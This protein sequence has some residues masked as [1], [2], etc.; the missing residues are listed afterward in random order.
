[1][2]SESDTIEV[3]PRPCWIAGHAEQGERTVT[4]LHPY[5]GTEIADVAV[6][7]TEQVERAVAAA[8]GTARAFAASPAHVRADVCDAIAGLIGQRSE[9]IAE[10]IT[11]ENGKPLNGAEAEVHAAAATFR[12]A[13]AEARQLAGDLRRLD[14]AAGGERR[15]AIVRH[16]PLGPVLAVS[17][18]TFPLGAVA[19]Q[20]APALAVGAPVIV[21]PA[22][23]TP[24]T[25][26][27]LG[28]IL[29]E[30]G[31]PEGAFSVLPVAEDVLARLVTDPQLPVIS[32]AGQADEGWAIADAAP[33]KHVLREPLGIGSVVVCPD[34]SSDADLA[35]AAGKIATFDTAR[36]VIV[37]ASVAE[38][39]VP[40]L[41]DTVRA[42]RTGSPHD[43]EVQVGPLIDEATAEQTVKWITSA[44][45]A[46]AELLTG[47]TRTGA[48]LAPTV[49]RDDVPTGDIPGPLLVVSVV[50]SIEAAFGR[51]NGFRTAVFT[52]DVATAF[53]ASATID[54]DV[55]VG[56]LPTGTG[57]EAVR[58]TVLRYTRDRVL[59]LAN[60]TV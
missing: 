52:H 29:A 14:I 16:R 11:A 55:V 53:A 24:M 19:R 46:G 10:T 49:L 54:A 47:G 6:P 38:K 28:E 60:V 25:A 23:A 20:I 12:F 41:V 3:Q 17:S 4:V 9:E 48:C 33:R 27:L 8:A 35:L 39:F 2:V 36:R 22:L 56:D 31:L 1:M 26:L 37:H 50:D 18:V 34:W 13:A 21:T 57:S 40:T 15:F 42:L 51:A 30:T 43:P 44:V 59:L 45:E 32:Y 7:G 5:D 58:S